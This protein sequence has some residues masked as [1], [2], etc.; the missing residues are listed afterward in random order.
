MDQIINLD[1]IVTVLF[2]QPRYTQ[3]VGSLLVAIAIGSAVRN[4]EDQNSISGLKPDCF[5]THA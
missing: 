5:G 4:A 1:Q 2:N 3:V